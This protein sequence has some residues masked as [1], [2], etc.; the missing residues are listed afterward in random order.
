[1]NSNNNVKYWFPV[2]VWMCFIFWMSTAMFAAQNTSSIIEPILRFLMPTIAHKE[3]EHIHFL[4][5]KLAHL[6]EYFISGLL[7]FRAFRSGS[8]EHH[9]W[10]W[11]LYS[12]LVLVLIAATDE[13]H[14]SFVSE[15]TSS[16]VDVGIDSIGGVLALV[17]STLKCR[18]VRS[19]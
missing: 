14:Q 3:L 15:R 4:I 5:R 6:T 10:R 16:I 11:A 19:K 13:Y 2:V 17:I 9:A 7:L 12:F 18:F 1:M 8:E